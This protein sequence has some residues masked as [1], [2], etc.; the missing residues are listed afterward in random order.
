MAKRKCWYK[1]IKE[2]DVVEVKFLKGH[3]RYGQPNQEVRIIRVY[4]SG[5][6]AGRNLK[7][8]AMPMGF[9]RTDWGYQ[10]PVNIIRKVKHES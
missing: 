5:D 1:N 2:G 6:F 8:E 7:G 4:E 3:W 10:Y 9:E